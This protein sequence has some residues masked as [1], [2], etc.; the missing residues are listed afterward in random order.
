M[1]PRLLIPAVILCATL[2]PIWPAAAE[3]PATGVLPARLWTARQALQPSP[4]T[5]KSSAAKGALIGAIVGGASATAA[6]YWAASTYGE[7]ESGGFCG[8]CFTI[9]GTWAIPAGA[10]GG[11]AIGYAIGKTSS[12]QYAS[13]VPRT[14]VAPVIGR[15]GGGV[16][17]T[18]RR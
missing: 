7:N 12:P 17:V 13:P 11:A 3:E 9:W 18:I 14:V 6:V 8:N 4:S 5:S 2:S 15:R 1:K 10:L 16:L